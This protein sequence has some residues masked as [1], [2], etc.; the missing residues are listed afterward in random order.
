MQTTL[1]VSLKCPE[2]GGAVRHL[3]GAYTFSCPFC[4]SVLRASRRG[5]STSYPK[6]STRLSSW[7]PSTPS[8]SKGGSAKSSGP[9][10]VKELRCIYKPFWYVKGM[11][12]SCHS[13]GAK[14]DIEAKTWAYTFEANT[15]FAPGLRTLGLRSEFLTV[16]AYD[17]DML[18]AGSVIAE[19]T[20]PMEA[21]EEEAL[22]VAEKSLRA[23]E[24][25]WKYQKMWMVGEKIFLIYYPVVAVSYT[26]SGESFTQLF[27]GV[28]AAPLGPD[29][30]PGASGEARGGRG[31]AETEPYHLRILTH[32]CKNCGGDLETGDFDIIFYCKN[33]TRLWLLEGN[34]Y[35]PE[36][37]TIIEAPASGKTVYIPFWRFEPTVISKSAGIKLETIAELAGFM[38]MGRHTLRNED[39]TRPISLYVPAIVARNAKAILKLAG[40]VSTFQKEFALDLGNVLPDERIWNV[41][42]S[43]AEAEE[44][45]SPLIFLMI[46][47]IDR[48]AIKFYN[49][50]EVTVNA[51]QLVWYPF[52]DN[53]A[54]L[55][56][57]FH[58]YNF[59]KRSMDINVY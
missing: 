13:S 35:H 55:V 50:H 30:S 40:R 32:R 33:C 25:A 17:S 44:L 2:C 48:V 36:K 41:S 7:M 8:M 51:C 9:V 45:L 5:S 46:G 11:L 6:S 54:Y 58:N 34:D 59:P 53:G 38:K 4:A 23:S 47:R 1:F 12:Y 42:L 19:V 15:D 16:K 22:D 29:A 56:D 31:A 3:Q 14:N 24:T 43:A 21:A 10:E 26:S 37:V 39:G 20:T 57:R 49:D 28:N 27:D 18:G 52:E